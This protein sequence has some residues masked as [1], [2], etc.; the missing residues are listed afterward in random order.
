MGAANQVRSATLNANV[1][2]SMKGKICL[3]TGAT[4]GIGKATAVGLAGMGA[5]VV[6]VGRNAVKTVAV[7]DEIKQRS[8]NNA[9]EA[10]IGDLS[11]MA[12]VRRVAAD[13]KAK[14][15]RLDVLIN[16]AGGLFWKRQVTADGFEKT[17]ALNHLNY[18]LLTNL[19]LDTLKASGHARIVNVSSDSHKG[20]RLDFDDLQSEKSYA[21]FTAYS[22]SKLANV[23]FSYE[24]ARRLAGTGVT[25]NVLHPGL[26]NTGFADNLGKVAAALYGFVMRFIAL[27]PEQGAQTSVYLASSPDVEG[28]TGQYWEKCKSL[29]SGKA[30]YD[31]STWGRLWDVSAKMVGE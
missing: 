3:V 8:G 17:W 26:V 31:E 19:L 27:T 16:N 12:E 11:V 23:V 6:I 22:R 28:V 7:V 25:V 1:K 4:S 29:Q 21:G 30:A 20:A 2:D 10:L 24:L 18:F 13:F 14:Y 5:T 9:V 15:P